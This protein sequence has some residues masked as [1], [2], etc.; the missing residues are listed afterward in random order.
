MKVKVK[1]IAKAAGVS[2]S[3]VSLVLNDKPCRLSLSTRERILKVAREMRFEKDQNS[4]LF[5]AGQG[6]TIG[7]IIP[8]GGNEFFQTLSMEIGRSLFSEGYTMLQCNA[9]LSLDCC[10][11]AL[12]NLA[13]KNVDG[14]IVIPPSAYSKDAGLVK[15]LKTIQESGIPMILVDQAV[16]SVFCDFITADNKYGGRIAAEHLI[17]K[18]RRKIGCIL[19]NQEVYTVRKRLEGYKQALAGHE[20]QYTD[21]LVWFGAFDRETGRKGAE[22]L[23]KQGVTGIFAGNDQIARGVYEYAQEKG[24]KIPEELSVTGFDNSGICDLLSPGL[25]SVEQNVVQMAQR[26]AEVMLQN[27]QGLEAEETP[28][29]YYFTPV[30]VERGSV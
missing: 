22:H 4:K 23:L 6:K 10:L 16:Y 21:N 27:I 26:A 29:N 30:L 9:G 1:D 13:C 20:L 17:H 25:T 28:R 7:L 24:I 2:P 8:D 18:G 12:E 15:M 14:M 5:M 11:Q 19:G 3:A